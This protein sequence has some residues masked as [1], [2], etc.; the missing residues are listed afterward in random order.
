MAKGVAT[1]GEQMKDIF[2]MLDAG[3]TAREIADLVNLKQ[4][5]IYKYRRRWKKQR[6]KNEPEV[7]E[8]AETKTEVSTGLADSDYAKAYLANDP[9]AVRS[10]FDIS[11]NVRIRSRKTGILYEMDDS[12]DEKILKITLGDGQTI[13]IEIGMFEKL[14]DEGIDVFLELKRTA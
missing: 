13:D 1:T 14:C 8:E 10:S 11:R 9:A 6:A 2:E 4:D 5:T 7:A 12:S 3:M